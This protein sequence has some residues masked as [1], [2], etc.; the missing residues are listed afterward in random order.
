[1]H[2]Q[3]RPAQGCNSQSRMWAAA[4]GWAFERAVLCAVGGRGLRGDSRWLSSS[5]ALSH[6]TS[7]VSRT[8]GW[9]EQRSIHSDSIL[10]M[11]LL[12]GREGGRGE[13]NKHRGGKGRS[14][15]EEE[16]KHRSKR[17]EWEELN[18]PPCL[19]V[20][21]CSSTKSGAVRPTFSKA[22]S[23]RGQERKWSEELSRDGIPDSLSLS[24]SNFTPEK[25]LRVPSLRQRL[26]RSEGKQENR[27]KNPADSHKNSEQHSPDVFLFPSPPQSS[28]A[29]ARSWW[30]SSLRA[31]PLLGSWTHSWSMPR[32]G[33]WN[34][35]LSS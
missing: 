20:D 29:P 32:E 13:G 12:H 3:V 21:L 6:S 24:S 27:E 1:M 18:K 2:I 26:H 31:L 14:T 30:M 22:P 25:C 28:L 15:A 17:E 33:T 8:S 19:A 7:L 34:V 9:T 4:I 35:W 5:S 23:Q 10:Q 16:E 11:T